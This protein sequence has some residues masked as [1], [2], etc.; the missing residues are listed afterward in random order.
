MNY[1]DFKA[2]N[3]EYKLKLTTR[4]TIALEKQIGC[5]PLMLFGTGNRVPTISEMIYVLHASLQQL[6]HG[7]NFDKAIDIFDK[8]LEDGH[9]PTDF[10]QVIID[11]Y[12]VS[13]IIS[14]DSNDSEETEKN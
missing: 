5:N 10:V 6:Q 2:G 9:T 4:T 3:S 7:I 8:Y 1:V 12:K 13:G 14:N 11:I